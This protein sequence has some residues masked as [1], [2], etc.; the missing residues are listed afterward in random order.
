MNVLL[1]DD[2]TMLRTSLAHHLSSLTGHTFLEAANGQEALDMVKARHIDLVIL[3]ILMPVMNGRETYLE[4]RKRNAD[5]KVI[6]LTYMTGH[7]NILFFIYHKANG[8]LRK[9]DDPERMVEAIR[10]VLEGGTYYSVEIMD[11]V[12]GK[13]CQIESEANKMNMT[14]RETQLIRSLLQG[15]GSKT[16]AHETGLSKN[17]INTYRERLLDK[18]ETQNAVEL[19]AFAAKNGL[20][21]LDE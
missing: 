16:I 19:I 18:T 15:K 20:L 17:T 8:F 14:A 7:A 13:L 11:A 5:I 4:L 2:H 12:N 9:S 10:I 6:V 1:V 3:D 21:N